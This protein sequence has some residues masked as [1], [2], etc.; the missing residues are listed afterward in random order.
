MRTGQHNED[1]A[2]TFA[3]FA[4][5]PVLRGDT[6]EVSAG[7]WSQVPPAVKDARLLN[8]LGAI[9]FLLITAFLVPSL[10][11]ASRSNAPEGFGVAAGMV[12]L[13]GG[14]GAI[15]VYQAIAIRKGIPGAWRQQAVLSILGLINF[16][17]GTLLNGLLLAKWFKPEVKAWFGVH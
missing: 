6:Q 3:P 14:I 4:P 11:Q 1:T 15:C 9:L 8:I 13:Y 16:P 12:M 7:D 10:F 5:T 2:E 17:L